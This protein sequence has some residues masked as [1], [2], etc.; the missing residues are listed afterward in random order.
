MRQEITQ[1]QLL[2]RTQDE[3]LSSMAW[4]GKTI[5][6]EASANQGLKREQSK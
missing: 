1:V 4:N 3:F 2:K 6:V 5:I